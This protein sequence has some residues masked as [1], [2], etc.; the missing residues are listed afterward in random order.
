ME[1]TGFFK[2]Y[3]AVMMIAVMSI[4]L[5]PS[6]E[7]YAKTAK[8][9]AK[10]QKKTVTWYE[11]SM[12]DERKISIYYSKGSDIPY[13]SLSEQ[14][15]LVDEWIKQT[16]PKDKVIS[17]TKG[18]KTTWTRKAGQLRFKAVFDSEKNTVY[19]DD[20]NGF[21]RFSG[22][23]LV[24]AEYSHE[25]SE[26][27]SPGECNYNRYGRSVTIDLSEYGIRLVKS[28]K[29]IYLPLQT[30]SDVI[31][32]MFG[33]FA[34]YN[35]DCVITLGTTSI[36][37]DLGKKY[38]EKYDPSGTEMSE[39]YALFNYNELCLAFD[40]LYGLKETHN[41]S[42]FDEFFKETGLEAL[43]KSRDSASV[44]LALTGAINMF[45]D[46]L[47]CNFSSISYRTSADKYTEGSKVL[48][49]GAF[50]KRTLDLNA[51][52]LAQRA[53]YFPEGFVPYQEIGDTA[54]ITFDT[55][56]CDP[57]LDYSTIP[58]D[59]ELPNLGGNTLKLV[60][61]AVSKITRKN[62]P[63]KRVVLDLT[64]NGGGMVC[65]A[66][67]LL[68]AFLGSSSISMK[69]MQ[70]GAMSNADIKADVNLDG[71][72][73]EKDTLAGRGLKLYCLISGYSYSCAN[74][75]P[76]MFKNTGKVT[77]IGRT[78]GGGSCCV[79]PMST[80]S[81]AILQVSGNRR[82]SFSKNGAMYDCDRGAEPDVFVD[83]MSKLYDREYVNRL[84]DGLN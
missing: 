80:A 51:E 27:F 58:T 54:Y 20:L 38:F 15:K 1:K 53:V 5:L 41:I 47:H 29:E 74:M 73:D 39:E 11:G 45:F 22:A 43:L 12:E 2:K 7:V 71:K 34:L 9:A 40:F 67:Y 50:R 17:K 13:I 16:S 61:Y 81:G 10:M 52:L 76:S 84:L 25:L 72:F 70:T 66:C 75:V 8:N 4:T 21:F 60:Q 35:G 3:L 79:Q 23:S 55:F 49:Q 19:F 28:G 31:L 46:D 83:D 69:N 6:G 37:L 24:G 56:M 32:S 36:P 14:V 44:D 65:T 57:D 59:D 62:S 77:L 68:S 63:V 82:F 30:F 33:N 64:C 42:S 48:P 26:L 78:S 18:N